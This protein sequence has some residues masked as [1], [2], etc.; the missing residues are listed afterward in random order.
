VTPTQLLCSAPF[1]L[2]WAWVAVWIIRRGNR[3]MRDRRIVYRIPTPLGRYEITYSG[4]RVRWLGGGQMIVGGL[5][6]FATLGA[7]IPVPAVNTVFGVLFLLS[8]AVYIL[9]ARLLRHS[10]QVTTREVLR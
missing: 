2:L 4:D 3:A 8:V 6:L 9:L 5:M 7:L 10:V 1:I